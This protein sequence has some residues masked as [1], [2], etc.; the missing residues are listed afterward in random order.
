MAVLKLF[1]FGGN[2]WYACCET[3][4]SFLTLLLRH[5]MSVVGIT[6]W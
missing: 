3:Q 1:Y 6:I 5:D 4:F 2:I